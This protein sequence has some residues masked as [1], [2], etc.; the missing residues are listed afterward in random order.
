M[1]DVVFTQLSTANHKGRSSLC[2]CSS[3]SW[4][5]LTQHSTANS[6]RRSSL[7]YCSC[8][9]PY[10]STCVPWYLTQLSTNKGR[11]SFCSSSCGQRYPSTC[12]PWYL[13]SSLPTTGQ[14]FAIFLQQQSCPPT[15][16]AHAPF[17]AGGDRR[18]LLLS[19]SYLFLSTA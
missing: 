8:G 2:S 14:F 15:T 12:V 1:C 13:P 11:S 3:V 6:N 19:C 4:Y 17:T 10:P 18:H 9:Q 5:K 16:C 7:C